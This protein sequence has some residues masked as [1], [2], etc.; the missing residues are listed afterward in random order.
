MELIKDN[1]KL[2][3]F[4]QSSERLSFR[5]LEQTDF[6]EW[7]KFCEDNT[8]LKYIWLTDKDSP[9]E[10]CKIWFDRVFNRYKNNLGGMNVLIEKNNHQFIG[11]SG[12]LIHTVD[13]IEE[14]EIGYSLM[15]KQRGKG[16]AIEAAQKC[17]NYAFE[18]NLT[19]SLI[20]II[21]ID[22]KESEKVARKNGMKLDKT[23]IYNNNKVNIFRISKSEWNKE[24]FNKAYR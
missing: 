5:Q 21:H 13:G 22:N 19:D 24:C 2:L 9:D 23:T 10:K 8:S 3:L 15:P 11:Q 4:G 17:R 7:L 20:S 12:L 16:Y 6:N 14:L 1:T 18:N